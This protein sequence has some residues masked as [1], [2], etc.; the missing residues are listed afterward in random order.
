MWGD[1]WVEA[2]GMGNERIHLR[3][4]KGDRRESTQILYK[5][6]TALF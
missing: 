6:V 5:L 3:Q 4:N 2:S 1:Y